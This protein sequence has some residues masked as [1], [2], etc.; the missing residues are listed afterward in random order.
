MTG[1][2]PPRCPVCEA[3]AAIKRRA[4]VV[5]RDACRLLAVFVAA[6][7]GGIILGP[8]AVND[9]RAFLATHR[10]P[11]GWRGGAG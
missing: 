10:A 8:L 3:N 11:D 2:R 5:A 1:A 4:E 7:D 9:V 6:H